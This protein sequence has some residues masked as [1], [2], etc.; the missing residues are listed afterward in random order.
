MLIQCGG[1]CREY[2]QISTFVLSDP[3]TNKVYCWGCVSTTPDL[4]EAYGNLTDKK[5]GTSLDPFT[6]P[7]VYYKQRQSMTDDENKRFNSKT[8]RQYWRTQ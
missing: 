2:K 6:D 3:H 1:K 8:L 7:T 4:L 5:Y